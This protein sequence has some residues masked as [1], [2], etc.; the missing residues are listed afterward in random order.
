M[1]RS[2][3]RTIAVLVLAMFGAPVAMHVVLHDLHNHHE[4]HANAY[5]ADSGHGD[6]EHP[7]VSSPAP[8]IPRLTQAELPIANAPAATAATWTRIPRTERN[9]V[10]LGALR[11]DTDVGF[12]PL[13]ATYLI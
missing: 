11:T 10:A 7:L 13:L 9:I 1:I 2:R 3:I 4:K 5:E 6:H 12:Q 8:Q